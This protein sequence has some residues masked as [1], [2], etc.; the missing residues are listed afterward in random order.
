MTT[1]TNLLNGLILLSSLASGAVFADM[2]S[3]NVG[4]SFAYKTQKTV[5]VD[6][7]INTGANEES[8]LS[9]YSQGAGGLRLLDS[10]MVDSSGHYSGKLRIPTSLKTIVVRSRWLD[11]FK[12]VKVSITK[13]KVNTVIDNF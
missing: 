6:I 9:F 1:Y 12:E 7:Q 10:R 5:A 8:G 2:N 13:N 3:L 11:S 4:D